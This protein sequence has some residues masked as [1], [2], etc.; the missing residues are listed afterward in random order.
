MSKSIIPAGTVFGQL[1]TTSH[2]TLVQMKRQKVTKQECLCT[3]GNNTLVRPCNLR[4][5]HTSSCGCLCKPHGMTNTR[6][7][8][9]WA[10]MLNRCSNSKNQKYRRYGGRGIYV[11][12]EWHTFTTFRD[13]ALSNGYT[14]KLSIDRENN[15]GNYE[16]SNCRWATATQQARNTSTNVLTEDLVAYIKTCAKYGLGATEI[17]NALGVRM[18]AVHRV[19]KDKNWR[20]VACLP[21]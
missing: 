3:C 12:P 16:P 20:E 13:W 1:T 5:G 2:T 21:V 10:H 4:S 15:D 19:I 8:R 7:F 17:S 11:C 18:H 9:I 14:P 6:I